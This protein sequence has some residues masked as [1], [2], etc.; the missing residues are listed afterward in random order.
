[1]VS[2]L[3]APIQYK[4]QSAH[5]IGPIQVKCDSISH[6]QSFKNPQFGKIAPCDATKG[7][8][9]IKRYHWMV[10]SLFQPPAMFFA[11]SQTYRIV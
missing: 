2:G 8:D 6:Q 7:N 10:Q 5:E 11:P 3:N 4:I 1:M 9:V